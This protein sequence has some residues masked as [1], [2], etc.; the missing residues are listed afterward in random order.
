MSNQPGLRLLPYE[1]IRKEFTGHPLRQS[2][3]PVEHAVSLPLPTLR[4]S[5]P[6]YAV[7][8]GA[9]RR[10]PGSP[11]ELSTPDRWWALA[12][13]GRHVLAYNLVS[14]VPFTDDLPPGPV[15]PA[16]A[17]R[18]I[19][20]AREGLRVVGELMDE[21]APLFFRGETGAGTLRSDLTEALAAEI[22]PEVR[23][24]YRAL[25]PDFFAWLEAS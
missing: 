17:P 3:V 22:S 2:E 25:V 23:P 4:W 6:A 12:A 13:S 1:Q 18:S 15:S 5:A 8:A 21:A 9:A 14:A 16:T 19:A 11:P 24:W 10:A 7:F 20:Q